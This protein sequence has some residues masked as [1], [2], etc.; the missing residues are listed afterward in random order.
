MVTGTVK[1]R[2]GIQPPRNR[3]QVYIISR[4]FY[5]HEYNAPSGELDINVDMKGGYDSIVQPRDY[6]KM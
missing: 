6:M 5:Y 4:Y 3:M 1:Q 2:E